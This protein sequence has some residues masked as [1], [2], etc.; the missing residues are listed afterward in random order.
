MKELT[1]VM[2]DGMVMLQMLVTLVFFIR[3]N[4]G[5]GMVGEVIG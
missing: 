1:S 2:Q 5:V 4:I 3:W